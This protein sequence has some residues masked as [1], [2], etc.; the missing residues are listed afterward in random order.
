MLHVLTA[1]HV[2]MW[3]DVLGSCRGINKYRQTM[4]GLHFVPR[5]VM[6]KYI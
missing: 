6:N 1:L 3:V 4:K 5:V 2:Y